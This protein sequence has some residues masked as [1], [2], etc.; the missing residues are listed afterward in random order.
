M[1]IP[2]EKRMVRIY[3]ELSPMA[4]A[5]YAIEQNPDVV[6]DRIAEI[7]QPY[8]IKS[9]RIDWHTTYKVLP[10]RW[11]IVHMLNKPRLASGYAPRSQSTTVS[12]SPATQ[13]TPTHP[14]QGKE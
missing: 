12:S 5:Q 6:M 13:S 7:L 10:F 4:A 11:F 8:I 14:K 9:T 1:V 3:T 2:R